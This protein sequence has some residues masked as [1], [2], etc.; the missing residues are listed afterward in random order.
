MSDNRYIVA[1]ALERELA[2]AQATLAARP[3]APAYLTRHERYVVKH[4]PKRIA[5]SRR[6]A[7]LNAEL[8]KSW[9]VKP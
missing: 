8:A 4:W 3:D 9:E 5:A 2:R 6:N 1:E 7:D